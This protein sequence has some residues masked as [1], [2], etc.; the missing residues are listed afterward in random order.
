MFLWFLFV[1]FHLLFFGSKPC[2][3]IMLDVLSHF[4]H[5]LSRDY[6]DSPSVYK[7]EDGE[8]AVVDRVLLCSDRNDKLTIKC[9]IR[10]TRRPEVRLIH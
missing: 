10:H 3:S 5:Y 8:T 7:L 9:I 1:M 4:T 2:C 6:K